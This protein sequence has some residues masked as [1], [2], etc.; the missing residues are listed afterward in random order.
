MRT[1]FL[2][3]LLLATVSL[4]APATKPAKPTGTG[5]AAKARIAEIDFSDMNAKQ[6]IEAIAAKSGLQIEV[7]WETVKATGASTTTKLRGRLTDVSARQ[8]IKYV[9]TEIDADGATYDEYADGQVFVFIKAE[10]KKTETRVYSV[11]PQLDRIAAEQAAKLPRG[12]PATEVREAALD[13]FVR[14]IVQHVAPDSW[15]DAG[16]TLGSISI[17]GAR[18]TVTNTRPALKEIEAYLKELDKPRK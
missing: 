12:T 16:G 2:V 5:A 9:M 10:L 6:A 17:T 11:G 18:M 3:V 1:V 8:A 7:D 4:A 15:R 13:D 14:L